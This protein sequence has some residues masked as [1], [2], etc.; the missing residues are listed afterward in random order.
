MR[1]GILNRW[2]TFLNL[3]GEIMTLRQLGQSDMHITP[4]GIGAWAMGG[5]NW[6]YG[7]GPQNDN[8]SVAAIHQALDRGTM[9]LMRSA[10]NW[11]AGCRRTPLG[12][13]NRRGALHHHGSAKNALSSPSVT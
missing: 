5:G 11:Q 6:E 8:D 2:R 12:T 3:S 4:L 10:S 1:R 7:W 9:V 13:W